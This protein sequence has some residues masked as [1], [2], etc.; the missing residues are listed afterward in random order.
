MNEEIQNI[1]SEDAAETPDASLESSAA[2]A[3]IAKLR[4]ENEELKLAA[5][6]KTAHGLF[7]QELSKLGARSPELLFDTVR[8]KIQFDEGGEPLNTAA[9]VAD[10]RSKFP[11]QFG[12]HQTSASIDAA[13]GAGD[14]PNFLTAEA[15]AKMTPQEIA[16]LDWNEVPSILAN[17]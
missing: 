2:L 9:L 5:R 10:L 13:A 6:M 16:R 15:L 7:T 1:E 3:E 4:R 17:N 14:R 12:S 8:G 11:E